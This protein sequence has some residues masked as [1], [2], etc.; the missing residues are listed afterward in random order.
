[1]Y[2]ESNG[3][4]IDDFCYCLVEKIYLFSNIG[5]F[6]VEKFVSIRDKIIIGGVV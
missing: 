3:G 4:N 1:M 2:I 5:C 6:F